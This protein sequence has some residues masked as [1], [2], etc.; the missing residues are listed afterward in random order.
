MDTS[1]QYIEIC[2]K[3]SEIQGAWKPGRGDWFVYTTNYGNKLTGDVGLICRIIPE[4]FIDDLE[5]TASGM[6]VEKAGW[7]PRLDQLW[8]LTHDGSCIKNNIVMLRYAEIDNSFGLNYQQHLGG[9]PSDDWGDW[10]YLEGNS[11]EKVLMQ[12]VMKEKFNKYWDGSNWIDWVI[13]KENK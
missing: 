9:Y 12:Y 1:K 2:R 5:N 6:S 4:I 13:K 7:L 3:A 10:I 8:D 11:R